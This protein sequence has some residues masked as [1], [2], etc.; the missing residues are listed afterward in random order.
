MARHS[1][2]TVNLNWSSSLNSTSFKQ[3]RR[4]ETKLALPERNRDEPKIFKKFGKR[5]QITQ[6][7]F[8][9]QYILYFA[10]RLEADYEFNF[11]R[12]FPISISQQ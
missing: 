10:F 5:G 7:T 9:L 3:G 1:C 12:H 8:E 11:N 4:A 6:T 2:D